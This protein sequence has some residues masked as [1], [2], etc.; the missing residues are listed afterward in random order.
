MAVLLMAV[1]LTAVLLMA[2]LLMVADSQTVA[3]S[4]TTVEIT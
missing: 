2:V 3:E 1:L 4:S